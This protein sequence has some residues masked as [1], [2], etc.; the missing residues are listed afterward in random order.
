MFE[1]DEKKKEENVLASAG[2]RF[3]RREYKNI[4]ARRAKSKLL[5]L[6]FSPSLYL[7]HFKWKWKMKP[8]K[9]DIRY[10]CGIRVVR[11]IAKD[12]SSFRMISSSNWSL[13]SKFE[14]EGESR[15]A[16]KEENWDE[17]ST[18]R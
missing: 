9:A 12:I 16:F 6:T 18:S 2:H 3:T 10:L 11:N 7:S 5:L 15:C 14:G 4:G 1:K 13:V 17:I 8:I